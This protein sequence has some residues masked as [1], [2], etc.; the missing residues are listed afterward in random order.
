MGTT[1]VSEVVLRARLAPTVSRFPTLQ[2][3]VLFGSWAKGRA[4][5]RSDLDVGVLTDDVADLD[6]WYGLL[7]PPLGSDR[8]DLVDLRRVDP[9]LA[10]EIA[11]SGVALFERE[12][13]LFTAFQARASCRYADTAPLRAAQRRAI[14]VFL[15]QQRL[16]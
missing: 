2:L 6:V 1:R 16:A 10:F 9:L 8:L 15:Q 5:R 14:Q 12:R 11:R 3:L 7:A 13:G 4:G